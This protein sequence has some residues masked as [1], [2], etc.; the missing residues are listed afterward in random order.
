MSAVR[1]SDRQDS[2]PRVYRRSLRCGISVCSCQL[3]GTGGRTKLGQQ[4]S[5]LALKADPCSALSRGSF[6]PTTDINRWGIPKAAESCTR[7]ARAFKGGKG[8]SAP[9]IY[10]GQCG[11]ALADHGARAYSVQQMARNCAK[12]K[13]YQAAASSAMSALAARRSGVSFPSVN[14]P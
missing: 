9:E 13:V 1:A 6:G 12:P 3:W 4:L 11:H 7:A 2:T 10:R 8:I 5:V 14:H